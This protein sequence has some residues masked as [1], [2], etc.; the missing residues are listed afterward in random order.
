MT[1][2]P[3]AD[4]VALTNLLEYL[5]SERGFDFTEYK[6]SSIE[7]R[8]QRR[9][10]ALGVASVSQYLGHL[11]EFPNE[12]PLLLDLLL[13]NVTDF[14]RDAVAWDALAEYLAPRLE[15]SLA[16]CEQ[17]RVWC[18]GCATGEEAYTIAMVLCELIGKDAFRKSVRIFATDIDE[19]A[20]VRARSGNYSARLIQSLN[21]ELREKYFTQDGASYVF[22]AD[23]RS[24]MTF[25]HHDLTAD[26]PIS[27]L[28][29]LSF[30]NTLIYFNA[31]LQNRILKR[32]R[33]ALVG[34]GL[35]F[36][37]RS[38]SV[39][40]EQ[41]YF[42]A[43]DLRHRVFALASAPKKAEKHSAPRERHS[44]ETSGSLG[45]IDSGHS[46][47]GPVA[48][49]LL[50]LDRNLVGANEL[51]RAQFGLQE[52]DLGMPIESLVSSSLPIDLSSAIETAH[53]L[54]DTQVHEEIEREL[55]AHDIQY[56]NLFVAPVNDQSGTP[57]GTT[58]VFHDVSD[59][60]KLRTERDLAR[61]DLQTL[62]EELRSSIQELQATNEELETSNEELQSVNEELEETNSELQAS[63]QRLLP[64][65]ESSIA[66]KACSLDEK[67]D[68]G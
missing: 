40:N 31:E 26:P 27:R 47:P 35:L 12:V 65:D 39:V 15:A 63:L 55:N 24:V 14:F 5:R 22:Q 23:L 1:D 41:R 2:S 6:R 61:E 48:Q 43:L 38:E 45:R 67:S 21:P 28:N 68:A 33:S 42:R 16:N 37:G 52:N 17:F 44:R 60:V 11:T 46:V 29:L 58:L 34:N 3:T 7:R 64:S 25:G 62:N 66:T 50:D 8:V 53:A 59:V 10:N 49:I 54:R 32:F 36:L 4:D 56:L 30:R 51:A 20:L 9:M 18:P 57:Q 19:H 13:I